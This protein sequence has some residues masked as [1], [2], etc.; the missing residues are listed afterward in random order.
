MEVRFKSLNTIWFLLCLIGFSACGPKEQSIKLLYSVDEPNGEISQT[1]KEVIERK[2][3]NIKVELVIGEG[4]LANLDSL[5]QGKADL[6]IIENHIPFQKNIQS[7]FPLYAQ[8]LHIF[9]SSDVEIKDFRELIKGRKV[10]IGAPGSAT[11][12]FMK[13]LFS[14]FKIT[15]GDYKIAE[16]PFEEGIVICGFTDIIKEENLADLAGYRLFSFGS[17]SD[18]GKGSLAEGISLRHPQV[19]PFAIPKNTYQELTIDPVMTIA[20]DAILVARG[21]LNQ[22]LVHDITKTIFR[23]QQEFFDISPLIYV[24]LK[25]NFEREKLNFPLHEGARVYLDRDEPSFIERYAEV[26]ALSFSLLIGLYSAI[27][28]LSR[29]NAQ[30]KKD[31]V[32]IFYH[33]LMKVKNEIDDIQDFNEAI[34]QIKVIKQGQNKAFKMLIDEELKADESFRI[35]MELSKETINELYLRAK[36]LK[37]QST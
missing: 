22:S 37:V 11:Y 30:R 8:I 36:R 1:F 34:K 3:P 18:F 23:D 7:L 28:S 19:R 24:D 20:S 10:Y 2:F 35:Y 4:S 27:K 16:S 6:T 21:D 32:D 5:Q 13:Q 31:R 29:W 17:V 33:D 25:E 15:E 14:Y 26:I 9:Y 12:G